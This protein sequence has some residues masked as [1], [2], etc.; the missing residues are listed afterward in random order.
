M[1]TGM[2]YWDYPSLLLPLCMS[3]TNISRVLALDW[4]FNS[5]FPA[6]REL[7]LR[8]AFERT[9]TPSHCSLPIFFPLRRRKEEKGSLRKRRKRLSAGP[10]VKHQSFPGV[11]EVNPGVRRGTARSQAAC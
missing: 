9:I 3:K 7:F 6:E 10:F 5:L 11:E 1:K 4:H 8:L 2:R